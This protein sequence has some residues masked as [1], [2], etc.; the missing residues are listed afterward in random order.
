MLLKLKTLALLSS[1]CSAAIL[2]IVYEVEVERM[3]CCNMC[4]WHEMVEIT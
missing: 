3:C 2:Q 4:E 1:I